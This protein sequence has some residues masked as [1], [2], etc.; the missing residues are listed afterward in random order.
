LNLVQLDT[1]YEATVTNFLQD[2]AI[3]KYDV[4]SPVNCRESLESV[5]KLRRRSTLC[6]RVQEPLRLD[7]EWNTIKLMLVRPTSSIST[8]F[9]CDL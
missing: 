3:W 7:E 5:A 1:S 6:Q 9:P 4:A 2:V 8:D